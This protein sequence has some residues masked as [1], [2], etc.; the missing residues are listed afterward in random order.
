[1]FLSKTLLTYYFGAI[2]DNPF[3]A[4]KIDLELPLVI[5]SI[6]AKVLI[7]CSAAVLLYFRG[8]RIFE[9]NSMAIASSCNVLSLFDLRI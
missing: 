4:P 1:M 8:A 5:S 6:P 2:F 7:N 3:K 9:S